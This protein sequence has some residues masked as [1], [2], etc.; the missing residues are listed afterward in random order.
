MCRPARAKQFVST[1]LVHVFSRNCSTHSSAPAS[2][3]VKLIAEGSASCC[4]KESVTT[5]A[6]P[7]CKSHMHN[8]HK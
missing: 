4:S 5:V 7:T 2:S 8:Q 6:R 3:A 1:S